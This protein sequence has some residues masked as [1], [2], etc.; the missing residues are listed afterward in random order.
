[1]AIAVRVIA[2]LVG[3]GILAFVVNAAILASGGYG[4]P[5]APLMMALG[6]GLAAGALAVGVA[7]EEG[8]RA[9]GVGLVVA[10]LAGEAWA[11]LQTAERTIAHRDQQQAPLQAAADT[12][13]RAAER[14]KAAADALAAI[15]DTPRLAKA[16]ATKDAA[17]AAVVSK[18][19][20]KGC[21][22]NC[23]KLLQ[24]QVQAAAEDVAA[25]R[26]EIATLRAA[27]EESLQQA[28]AALAA[29][30]L[31]PS[32][33]PLA[34]RL[35][36]AAWRLDI[37]H[38][39]LASVAANGLAALLLAFAAHGRRPRR[40]IHVMP[41]PTMETPAPLP[42][43][44][45]SVLADTPVR[46][47]KEEADAFARSAF[48]PSK[49]GRVVLNDIPAAYHAWCRTRGIEPLSTAE[50]GAALAALFASVGLYRR[51][52]G[53]RAAVPGIEWSKVPLRIEG[54]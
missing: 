11:L 18:A 31:P 43:D 34:D 36:I 39:A 50:I 30:P 15:G 23:A 19:A 35:G 48:R 41:A 29:L 14:V 47:A 27:A 5:A 53:E 49:R 28:R 1:M 52:K 8:R 45:G 3:L 46:D 40:A 37:I 7:W 26:A 17:D 10:L 4:T 13:V 6:A 42:D 16:Q 32:G 12:R 21:V 9:L 24:A 54:P 44:P 25:A 51:G 22:H 20:E 38:A 33:T 2:G